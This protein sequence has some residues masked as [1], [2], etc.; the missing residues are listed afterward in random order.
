MVIQHILY[1]LSEHPDAKDTP[2]GILRWW[3]PRG[4]VGQAEEEVQEALDTLVAKGWLTQRQ[5]I[6]PQK[7]YMLN[8]EK[9]DEIKLFLREIEREA[10]GEDEG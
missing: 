1:Y 6:T 7:L 8:K 2:R 4:G 10:E 9:L 3:C 5:M